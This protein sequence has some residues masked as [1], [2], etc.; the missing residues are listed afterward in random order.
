M[1]TSSECR[2]TVTPTAA[3]F[4]ST[5]LI[6]LDSPLGV[7]GQCLSRLVSSCTLLPSS[8]SSSLADPSHSLSGFKKSRTT[9][10]TADDSNA[11]SF[12][13]A[14]FFSFRQTPVYEAEAKVH[15]KPVTTVSQF[16]QGAQNLVD[17]QT[18]R[19]I[20]MSEEVAIRAAENIQPPETPRD[21]LEQLEVSVPADTQI[22]A[23]FLRGG[24]LSSP[25]SPFRATTLDLLVHFHRTERSTPWLWYETH[26]QVAHGGLASGSCNLWSGDGLLLA[27]SMSQVAFLPLPG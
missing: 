6:A 21:L 25:E 3:R 10:A 2:S 27:T 8:S 12:A 24:L 14:M 18:E 20:A 19:E 26:V 11:E 13:S 1:T 23:A 22:P 9:A 16:T 5:R 4:D 15:V 17:L 7:F